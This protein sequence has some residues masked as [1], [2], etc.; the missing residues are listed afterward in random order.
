MTYICPTWETAANTHLM[1]L[2]R[3]QNRILRVI[4]DFA[5][6]T[7]IQNMHRELQIPYVY[8]FITKN[9]KKQAEIIYNH[10]NE[11]VSNIGSCEAQ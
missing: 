3:V 6:R 4:G 9:C 8:D 10:D 1:K 2:Q 11:N 7:Q 5:R